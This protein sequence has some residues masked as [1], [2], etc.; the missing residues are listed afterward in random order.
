MNTLKVACIQ[1]KVKKDKYDNIEQLAEI[2]GEKEFLGRG[3][4]RAQLPKIKG[5]LSNFFPNLIDQHVRSSY[6]I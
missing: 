1:Q 3:E 5:K 6:P 4:I 2:L